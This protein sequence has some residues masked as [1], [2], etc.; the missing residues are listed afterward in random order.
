M[1]KTVKHHSVSRDLFAVSNANHRT[2]HRESILRH[3][4]VYLVDNYN[5]Y[6]PVCTLGTNSSCPKG[7]EEQG[8]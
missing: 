2:T 4:L 7:S 5:N 1:F 8:R 3:K 6:M